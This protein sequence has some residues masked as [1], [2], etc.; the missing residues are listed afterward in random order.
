[1]E[2]VN[3]CQK[4]SRSL[5]KIGQEWGGASK[6]VI[7]ALLVAEYEARHFGL[8]PAYDEILKE[9]YQQDEQ[10]RKTTEEDQ[11]MQPTDEDLNLFIKLRCKTGDDQIVE[12]H[13][14]YLAYKTWSFIN[15]KPYYKTHAFKRTLER[16]GFK[17]K[18]RSAGYFYEKIGLK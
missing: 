18:R 8:E 13:R 16:I 6:V 9:I 2:T 1:M 12:A 4:T 11:A 10:F 15:K 7:V 3:I 17:R 14:I 5:T